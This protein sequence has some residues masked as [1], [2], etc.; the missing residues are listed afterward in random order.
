MRVELHLLL[1]HC[2]G[3]DSMAWP[4]L[5]VALRASR[6]LGRLTEEQLGDFTIYD[7][8]LIVHQERVRLLTPCLSAQNSMSSFWWTLHVLTSQDTRGHLGSRKADLYRG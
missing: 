1:H 7:W 5:S 4:F 8:T 3:Q 2:R 6:Q